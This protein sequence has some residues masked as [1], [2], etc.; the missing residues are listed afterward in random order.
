MIKRLEKFPPGSWKKA[1]KID[2]Y[3]AMKI[4]SVAGATV[5]TQ[6]GKEFWGKYGDFI[7]WNVDDA[8]N[9]FVVSKEEFFNS[10]KEFVPGLFRNIESTE[11]F[12]V[13]SKLKVETLNGLKTADEG[14]Y[15]KKEISGQLD[16]IPKKSFLRNYRLIN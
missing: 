2:V 3:K 11:V 16:V 5:I 14:D 7:V 4:F 12:E 1:Q 13:K 15:L 6:T 8:D 10:F 9:Q